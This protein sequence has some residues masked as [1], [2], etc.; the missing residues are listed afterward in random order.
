MIVSK[1]EILRGVNSNIAKILSEDEYEVFIVNPYEFISSSRFD[2][3]IKVLYAYNFVNGNTNFFLCDLY[4]EHIRAFNQ[5]VEAD[6][7]NKVGKDAFIN[8]FNN[9]ITSIQKYGYNKSTYIPVDNN[10]LPFDGAHRIAIACVFNNKIPVFQLKQKLAERYDYEFFKNRGLQE[11]YID[12]VATKY[13]QFKH[14]TYMVLVWP[15]SIGSE[16]ELLDVLKKYGEIVCRKNVKLTYNGLVNFQRIVYKR[17]PWVGNYANDF[18]GVH[19]KSSQC[20]DSNGILRAFL[21]ESSQD[22]VEMKEEIRKIFNLGKHAVHINDTREETIEISRFIFNDNAINYLNCAVRK[23][24]RNFNRLFNEFVSFINDNKIDKN[25]VAIIGGVLPL[26]GIRDAND[27]DYISVSSMPMK[28]SDDIEMETKKVN[29]SSYS[30]NEIINDPKNYLIYEG[31][32]FVSLPVILE[33]KEKRNNDSD[34]RDAMYIRKLLKDGVVKY[35]FRERL[36]MLCSISFY[37]RY[38]KIFLLKVRFYLYL[39]RNKLF[40]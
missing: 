25:N 19:T 20:F 34:K 23:E 7:S 5:F 31:I 29:Y 30:V 13:A 35:T 4:I 3:L 28:I 26:Y 10:Y 18:E 24:M 9:V 15:I 2:I 8:N 17:E 12:Y 36:A 38:V 32:K 1:S 39:L 21:F 11:Y 6:N 22:M 27:L 37:R 40:R 33:I 16:D 14:N